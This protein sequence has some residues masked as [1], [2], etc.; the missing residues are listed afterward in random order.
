MF[1]YLKGGAGTVRDQYG[2]APY[3]EVFYK[4]VAAGTVSDDSRHARLWREIAGN[5]TVVSL[6]P[7]SEISI[8]LSSSPRISSKTIRRCSLCV[9]VNV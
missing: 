5:L 6:W 1:Q 4:S 7:P 8:K 9:N 3:Y 2:T